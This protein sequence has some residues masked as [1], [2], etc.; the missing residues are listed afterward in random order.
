MTAQRCTKTSRAVLNVAIIFASM[1]GWAETAWEWKIAARLVRRW[2]SAKSFSIKTDL[3]AEIDATIEDTDNHNVATIKVGS[4]SFDVTFADDSSATLLEDIEAVDLLEKK[5][6][7]M[8]VTHCTDLS[9]DN[10]RTPID[11]FFK[12]WKTHLKRL[13]SAEVDED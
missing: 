2:Q 6:L 10:D 13:W 1:P 7:S 4:E 9:A 12:A 11:K 5:L 3:I 8:G